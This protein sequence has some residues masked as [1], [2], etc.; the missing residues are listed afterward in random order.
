MPSHLVTHNQAFNEVRDSMSTRK[1]QGAPVRDTFF[2]TDV[3]GHDRYPLAELI[4]SRATSGGGRGGRTRVALYLAL[5]WVAGGSPHHT[6]RP[7]SFWATL[8]GLDDPQNS[9]SRVIRST[10]RELEARG[11][12]KVTPG[13]HAGEVPRI[14]P[15]REDGSGREYSIPTGRDGDTYRR[16]PEVAFRYVVPANDVTGA[17]LVMYLIALRT[18]ERARTNDGLIF[19]TALVKSTYGIGASTRQKGLHNLSDVGV[20]DQHKNSSVDDSGGVTHR[21]RQR[22]TYDL[23]PEYGRPPVSP[24]PGQDGAPQVSAAAEQSTPAAE[25]TSSVVDDLPF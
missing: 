22:T 12:V 17:G 8:L 16:V 6:E 9:G 10:W 4:S 2:R 14:T 21:R 11:F 15:L 25:Q 7:A 23:L 13:A 5:L 18:A 20:L 1:G 24:P 19:P 3:D